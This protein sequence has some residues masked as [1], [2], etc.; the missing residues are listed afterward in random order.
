MHARSEGNISVDLTAEKGFWWQFFCSNLE[1]TNPL[2]FCSFLIYFCS[3]CN[4]I[5]PGKKRLLSKKWGGKERGTFF[6]FS[7]IWFIAAQERAHCRGKEGKKGLLLAVVDRREER[8]G[9]YYFS[10]IPK[11]TTGFARGS[12]GWS[13]IHRYLGEL[14]S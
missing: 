9:L 10:I 8:K 5:A 12:F 6:P 11:R 13:G 3:R 7:V 14:K 4:S 2:F 1:P